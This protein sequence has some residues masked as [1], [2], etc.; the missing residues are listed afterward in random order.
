MATN[1]FAGLNLPSP[2][3]VQAANR[4]RYQEMWASGQ[5]FAMQQATFSNFLDSIFGNPQEN[6]AR[7]MMKALSQ[8][9]ASVT[10]QEGDTDVDTEIRRIKAMRDAV[11]DRDPQ[12]ASQLNMQMLQLGQVKLEQDKLKAEATYKAQAEARAQSEEARKTQLFPWELASKANEAVTEGSEG[13]NYMHPQT[14]QMVNVPANDALKRAELRAR[15]YV[16]AGKPTLQGSKDDVLGLT[17]PVATD[18]QTSIVNGAKQLDAFAQ[19][20]Q[21]WNPSFLTLPTQAIQWANKG[22]E[23]LTGQS[24][25]ADVAAQAQQYYDFRVQ[26]MQA[27]NSYIKS[28][29]GAQAAV[30]E[31]DRLERSFPN[32][33]MSPSEYLSAL[34]E[35]VKN[36]IGINKRA[37]QALTQGLNVT[38]DM[39]KACQTAGQPCIWD[40]I[41]TPPVS[42]Q[43]VDAFLQR[44]GVPPRATS[45]SVERPNG[46][47]DT[48]EWVTMP[49][50]VKVRVKK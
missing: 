40:S 31:Y 44:F 47:P 23:R 8:A 7:D 27:L 3:Q 30:A 2:Q 48:G 14:G 24:V 21:K 35:S 39:Q 33:N 4:A 9:S 42:D 19:I 34:R 16:E 5:P 10:P 28:I 17:K 13:V 50:G 37:Q 6:Q 12:T 38:P 41:A 36:T 18:L 46:I 25:S 11:A 45:Q 29:T 20:A 49:N 26:T 15:G 1:P 43:E 32:M 22:F